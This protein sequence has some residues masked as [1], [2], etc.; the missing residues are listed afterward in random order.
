MRTIILKFLRH[1]ITSRFFDVIWR[2]YLTALYIRLIE[3]QRWAWVITIPSVFVGLYILRFFTLTFPN[4]RRKQKDKYFIVRFR[5]WLKEDGTWNSN[6][7]LSRF[8]D[9]SNSTIVKVLSSEF[10]AD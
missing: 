4:I 8:S 10:E 5:V 3:L 7:F 2:A 6:H 1:P 9:F